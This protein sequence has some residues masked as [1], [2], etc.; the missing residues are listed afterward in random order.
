MI[1]KRSNKTV[2]C[3]GSH[4]QF[5]IGYRFTE[6][7]A[8]L[9]LF[10]LCW[11]SLDNRT[12]YTKHKVDDTVY[13]MKSACYKDKSTLEDGLKTGDLCERGMD[14]FEKPS[15][16]ITEGKNHLEEQKD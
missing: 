4:V 15:T 9:T 14:G 2:D 1:S 5:K 10:S 16:I 11:N 6:K 7:H 12:L 3:D 8:F 13:W